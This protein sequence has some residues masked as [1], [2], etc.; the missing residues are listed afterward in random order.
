MST[1]CAKGSIPESFLRYLESCEREVEPPWNTKVSCKAPNSPR[2]APSHRF[3]PKA[4]IYGKTIY[5][6]AFGEASR[7]E[8]E[9]SDMGDG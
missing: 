1:E 5:P 6:L 4:S 7:Y 9:P 2:E 8:D 3:L